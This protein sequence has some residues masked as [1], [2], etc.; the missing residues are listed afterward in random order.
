MIT[1]V[2]SRQPCFYFFRDF[3][4]K[5]LRRT[6]TNY[7]TQ[8]M[9]TASLIGVKH[10]DAIAKKNR[11]NQKPNKQCYNFIVS[12]YLI[13]HNNKLVVNGIFCWRA[14]ADIDKDKGHVIMTYSS[15]SYSIF[16]SYSNI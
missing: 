12:L 11:S 3:T 8:L 6:A 1:L 7:Y 10:K 16:T 9:N 14:T 4:R 2:I 13:W 15:L 5:K